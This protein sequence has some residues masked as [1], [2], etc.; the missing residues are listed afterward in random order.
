MQKKELIQKFNEF[1]KNIKPEDRVAVF[2]HNDTDG[3]CSG[4]LAA[5]IVER[6]RN[7]RIDL[8]LN[9]EPS[10]VTI[11]HNHVKDL[12]KN[13]INK[14]ICVDCCIDQEPETVSLV[15]KFAKIL[16]IDHHKIYNNI[17]SNKTILIKPQMLYKN[18]DGAEYCASKFLFDLSPI[19]ISDLDWISLIGLIG[20]VNH[21]RWGEFA[22]KILKKYKIKQNK[23]IFK[24]NLGKTANLINYGLVLRENE[25]VFWKVY[26]AQSPAELFKLVKEYSKVEKEINYWV[27]NYKKLAEVH[28]GQNLIFYEIEPKKYPV[29][30]FIINQI[31]QL[32]PHTT[33]VATQISK[34]EVTFS[35]RRQDYKIKMNDLLEEAVKG[36]PNASAGGHIPAAG[37]VIRTEDLP[38]FKKRIIKILKILK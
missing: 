15:E 19:D 27:K 1:I 8:R 25:A 11:S 14:V 21:K 16:A 17:T 10:R 29:K 37:G 30:S 3:V 28:A 33:I 6:V 35:A 31:S 5:K 12:E 7:K 9:T 20:D 4:V 23:D 34:D 32:H 24:T 18:E 38:E 26:S 13:K 2:H 36:L 22:N